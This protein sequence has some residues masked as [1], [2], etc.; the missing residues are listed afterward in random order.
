LHAYEQPA[1]IQLSGGPYTRLSTNHESM[2][3]LYDAMMMM[4]PIEQQLAAAAAFAIA[5]ALVCCWRGRGT[6]AD[7]DQ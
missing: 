3:M 1:S 7:N 2:M 6:H 4:L 5:T